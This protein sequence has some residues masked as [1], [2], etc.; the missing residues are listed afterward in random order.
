MILIFQLGGSDTALVGQNS[1]TASGPPVAL[2]PVAPSEINTAA[3]LARTDWKN[4]VD[5]GTE[6]QAAFANKTILNHLK[7]Q[8]DLEIQ[9][10]L[11]GSGLTVVT[12]RIVTGTTTMEVLDTNGDPVTIELPVMSEEKRFIWIE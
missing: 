7:A 6:L 3:R 10:T 1:V 12:G 2:D 8:G 11:K 9:G 5:L 4:P